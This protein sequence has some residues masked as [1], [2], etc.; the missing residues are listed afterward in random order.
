M[1]EA[2]VLT[3]ITVTSGRPEGLARLIQSIEAQT[4]KLPFMHLLLWDD[5][6]APGAQ[7]PDSYNVPGRRFSIVFPPGWAK[8]TNSYSL[9]GAP[10]TV[11]ILVAKTPW[12]MFADDDVWWESTH[13]EAMNRALTEA[14]AHWA[15]TLRIVWSPEN[16][17]IG[18]DRFESV[19]DSPDRRVPYEMCDNNTMI[20][21][22]E[23]GVQCVHAV[24]ETQD[25]NAD[26]LLYQEL[27]KRGGTPGFTNVATIN[28]TCPTRL[29]EFFRANC[30]P[31]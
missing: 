30:S 8:G 15:T 23:L 18:V 20:Y 28:Q 24:H 9:G 14:R 1:S 17:R 6:R 22:R 25:Y 2:P 4:L 11:G 19:G 21:R 10:T 5:F 3:I 12:I 7:P 31:T 26:R 29:A 16:D 27:K 13:L